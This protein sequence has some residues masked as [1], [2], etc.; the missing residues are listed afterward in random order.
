[1]AAL[2]EKDQQII[3]AHTGLIHRVVIGCRNRD[4]VPDLED[5]L[6]QLGSEEEKQDGWS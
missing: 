1:M 5:I 2:P 6:N 3:D 4:M